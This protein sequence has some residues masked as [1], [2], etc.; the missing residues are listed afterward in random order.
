[1]WI[2]EHVIN[3]IE[4]YTLFHSIDNANKKFD[5][6]INTTA[7][8]TTKKIALTFHGMVT[9]RHIAQKCQNLPLI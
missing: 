7:T 6:H 3:Y 4:I 5:M 2:H 9:F 8:T 1:M